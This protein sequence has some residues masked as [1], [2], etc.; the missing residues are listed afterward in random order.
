MHPEEYPRQKDFKR[1]SYN[2]YTLLRACAKHYQLAMDVTMQPQN[3]SEC[4][5]FNHT[6]H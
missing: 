5:I 3:V 1:I 2:H 4:G 6:Q